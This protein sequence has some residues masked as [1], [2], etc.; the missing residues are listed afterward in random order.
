MCQQ[1]HQLLPQLPQAECSGL[2]AGVSKVRHP[3]NQDLHPYVGKAA[4]AVA[5]TLGL[6]PVSYQMQRI[7]SPLRQDLRSISKGQSDLWLLCPPLI[8]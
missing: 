4:A 7:S 2:T 3:Q 8:C 1:H 6:Q 5:A